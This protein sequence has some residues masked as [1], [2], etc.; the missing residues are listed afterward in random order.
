[1]YN[2]LL[3]NV[4]VGQTVSQKKRTAKPDSKTFLTDL[5]Y[6]SLKF[7]RFFLK[8]PSKGGLILHLFVQQSNMVKMK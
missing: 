8:R 2:D 5:R 4:T 7:G 6:T 1:M 3:K